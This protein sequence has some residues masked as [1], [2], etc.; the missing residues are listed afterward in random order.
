MEFLRS[1]V[2]RHLAGKPVVASP[3][4]GCFLRLHLCNELCSHFTEAKAL[5]PQSPPRLYNQLISYSNNFSSSN[6]EAAVGRAYS[7]NKKTQLTLVSVCHGFATISVASIP[8][9]RD[10][11]QNIV[12][13]IR[14][15]ETHTTEPVEEVV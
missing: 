10:P 3:N 6:L 15:F 12:W 2:R 14:T 9:A 8:G 5:V 11:Y 13:P 7:H 4:V 1:F